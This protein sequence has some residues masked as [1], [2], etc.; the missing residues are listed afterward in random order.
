MRYRILRSSISLT[1]ALAAVRF[2]NLRAGE[3]QDFA[4][5]EKQFRDL[6]M[7]AR[8]L[9]GP[10]F[11]LHGD[12]SA[13]RLQACLEKVAQ[14]GNGCFT[15]ESRPHNDWLGPGWYR[16]LWICLEA[17]KKLNLEMWIFDERWWPSGEVGG[18]VPQRYGTK[19]VEAK[20]TDVEGP[21]SLTLAVPTEKLVAVVAGQRTGS[22]IVGESLTDL[23]RRVRDG[24]LTWEVPAGTWSVMMFTWRYGEGRRGR[25]LVDGASK[26]AVEW[27]IRTVYQPHYDEFADDFG[28]TIVGYFYDEPETWG[29]WGSEVM[30]ML[31][32]RGIDWKKALV[33]W[34][35]KL[36][37]EEQTTMKYQ[38]R[39]ALAE[40]WGRTLYGGLTEWCHQHGV[41]SIGHFL[42]HN[43]EYLHAGVCAGNMFQ[44]Q[45][46]SDMG[47]IDA[48]FRQ[49]APGQRNMGLWQTP[50]L[51]SSISHAYGKPDDLA[52]VEIF[53]ARGQDLSYPEMKWW[54]DHMHVSGINF[55]IPHSFN[56]RAP[57]DRDCPPY[58]YNGGYEP[59]WPLYRVYADYTS[60]L[61]LMLSGGRHV[62]P[63]AFLY[64]GNSHH[65]GKSV[66]PEE[67]TTA[68]Q[69]ALF[70]CDWIPYGVFENDVKTARGELHLRA[71][72]YR[73]LVVPAVEVI[74]YGTLA[75]VKAFFA[76]GGLVV[77]YGILPTRSATIGKSAAD[78]A[79]LR[80]AIWGT[81]A[82]PGL[83]VCRTNPAGG[84]AYLLPEKPTPEELQQVLTGDAGFHQTL[85]VLEGRTSHWLHVLHRVKAG[86]DVFLVCNQN[87]Q[88]E[89][90]RFRFR[91]HARGVPECWD[92]MR[93]EI[94]SLPF[95]RVDEETVE[96]GLTLEPL[97]SVLVVFQPTR[98]D[99]P[100]R[101]EDRT[102]PAR[103]PISVARQESPP[104]VPRS[105]V[106]ESK[107][108]A[109]PL[110]GCQWV[111]FPESTSALSAPPSK[112]YFR[113]KLEIPVGREI[114]RAGIVM[115]ADN[116]FQLL[117]N[118]KEAG[119][120]HD[121]GRAL[122]IELTEHLQ[123]GANQLAVAAVNG[124]NGPNPAGLIG[125]LRVEF[126]E[127]DP[128]TAEIDSS[129]KSGDR[130]ED[131]WTV[132]G[133]DDSRWPAAKPVAPFGSG[134]WGR[135]TGGMLTLA[136]VEADPLLGRFTLPPDW[137]R[138]GDRVCLEAE[139]IEPE[140]AARV[141]LNGRYVG[142][143]IGK[144]FRLDITGSV[145][146]GENSVL[147]EPFA[148]SALRVVL[149]TDRP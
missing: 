149:Y 73:V 118:G 37:G 1:V 131:G 97:E 39:E 109:I 115:T 68:L 95:E 126:E 14:G 33:A 116:E 67:L 12:E 133:F 125:R 34:K 111:W 2:G 4:A 88:G 107:G 18:K 21:L 54:T 141:E 53:G 23:G 59:R 142:G 19:Y 146:S 108:D 122:E 40:A 144:P 70:D 94:T 65:V 57:F 84:R 137:L 50:K 92:A 77:G 80:Q 63:V 90:R 98:R 117:V 78:I 147:L 74:P 119:R 72:R 24:R 6:P 10:L 17:A 120:G 15:A 9:T 3:T 30:P 16:D 42:E 27:Y 99:L 22:A 104:K 31:R 20:A 46:Y 82:R 127:G 105:P 132:L 61:S 83:E 28:K 102:K 29:D 38:Y 135:L 71:E 134:P 26:D 69:D 66:K 25:F 11:W 55:H 8:R 110:D 123:P 136:P 106:E 48:V 100:R 85:E 101:L 128:L 130:A 36:A 35:F 47:A 75:K 76:D 81:P 43:W 89:A 32:E 45:K 86:R 5:L 124:G 44:L 139:A 145:R 60:R 87:H 56:P 91:A 129:W 51:G 52:M 138:A 140:A 143:F 79:I 113:G 96:F 121:W 103:A 93:G 114:R 148:P 112:R 58:F 49:F 7:E 62:C 64:L 13:E 41:L